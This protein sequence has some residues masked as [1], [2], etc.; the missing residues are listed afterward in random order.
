MQM[1]MEYR[2]LA[3]VSAGEKERFALRAEDVPLPSRDCRAK[4]KHRSQ[5]LRSR[6]EELHGMPFGND[7]RMPF[8]E[9]TDGQESKTQVVLTDQRCGRAR[10][11][12]LAE[13]A[14]CGFR[15][16][17]KR[18]HACNLAESRLALPYTRTRHKSQNA[19][20]KLQNDE[21]GPS[22]GE[23]GLPT[24]PEDSS[25]RMPGPAGEISGHSPRAAEQPIVR[26]GGAL[27]LQLAIVLES[28]HAAFHPAS[29]VLGRDIDRR[30]RRD[31]YARIPGRS[32]AAEVAL[33]AAFTGWRIHRG[34]RGRELSGKGDE[35]STKHGY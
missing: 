7:K 30:R 14:S 34:R 9:R 22:T 21:A 18:W 26:R 17:L 1:Q 31:P 3:R 11:D 4:L 13:D 23:R 8:S 16:F 32:A 19:K 12:D 25:G 20:C 27:Q 24:A 2:L 35:R 28:R 29:S 10:G 5:F 6:I 15:F 33:T